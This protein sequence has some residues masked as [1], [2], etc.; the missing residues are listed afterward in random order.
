MS[1]R[2]G[3]MRAICEHPDDDTPRLVFANGLDEHDD[4]DRAEFIR[5]QIELA[6]LPDGKKKQARQ[7]REKELLDAHATK[8]MKP[9]KP[10]F[11]YYYEGDYA[12]YYAP[13]VVFRRGFVETIAM[14]VGTFGD[15]ADEVF[16]LAPIRVLRLQDAQPLDN[17][18]RCEDLLRLTGLNLPGAILSADGSDAPVL[19][20]SKYLANLTSLVA[21]GHDDNGHLDTAGL[22][23]LAGTRHLTKLERLDISDNWLFGSNVTARESTAHRKLL[24]VLGE[25]MPALREL[26]LGN[27]GLQ[28]GEVSG[29]TGHAW[30]S[31]LR[32]LDLRNNQ[33]AEHGCRSLCESKH[34]ADLEKLELTGN[35]H[36]DPTTGTWGPLNSTVTQMLKKRFGKG[37]AL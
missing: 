35:E 3:F 2:D 16:A 31:R 14:D 19:F 15:R 20:R 7:V 28:D 29:L 26:R 22:R 10:Y 4:P 18:A 6:G 34:L 11:A 9:L 13:P 23:A 33:L 25:K 1:E 5:L 36:R 37:V 30:V 17:L 32:V 27:T 21:R 8:W 12:H 24:W